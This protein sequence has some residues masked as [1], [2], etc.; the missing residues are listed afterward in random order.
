MCDASGRTSENVCTVRVI[1][2]YFIRSGR[3]KCYYPLNDVVVLSVQSLP[4]INRHVSTS[5]ARVLDNNHGS[6]RHSLK[7]FLSEIL[8]VQD[9][10][11]LT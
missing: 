11:P 10:A 9:S 8:G 4:L 7:V 1:T 5:R 2:Y 3:G 6:A